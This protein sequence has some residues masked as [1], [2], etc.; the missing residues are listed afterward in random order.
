[1]ERNDLGNDGLASSDAVG[2]AGTTG[3]ESG[4]SGTNDFSGS[5][6]RSDS[7]DFSGS[8]SPGDQSQGLKDRARNVIGNAGS[9]LA[10]VGSTVRERAGSAKDKLADALETGA[11]KL[12]NRTQGGDATLAGAT[13]GGSTAIANDGRVAQ[14]S[15]RV[16]GGMERSAE[17]LR[18]A[19]LDGLKTGVEQQVREH[20][21]RTLLIAV[22]LG[23]LIGRAF[24]SE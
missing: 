6:Q 10:D 22:G 12:R 14:I 18:D 9:R 20:P 4:T 2:G 13:A 5:T 23:Y 21:A 1:M 3:N 15:D 17:W 8:T 7:F 24:R 19:D 11:E 16:A